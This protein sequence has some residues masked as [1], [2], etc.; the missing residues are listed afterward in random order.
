MPS[1]TFAI[2]DIHGCDRALAALVE[3]IRPTAD[4][5]LV[6]L[7][8]VVDRGPGT[9]QAIEQLLELQQTCRLVLILGNHDEMMIEGLRTGQ[10]IR[11]WLI[12]GGL[13]SVESYG[14]DPAHIPPEHLEFLESGLN[15]WQ[16][17]AHIFIHANLEPGVP[18]GQQTPEWL[19]WTHVSGRELPH[20]SGRRVICGHTSLKNGVP[21]VLPGW[22]C[23]DT[24]AFGGK[25]LTALDVEADLVYR[26]D[27]QGRRWEPVPLGEIATDL[28]ITPLD[29]VR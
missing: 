28:R 11:T 26:A 27:Q 17:D 9:R 10:T 15:Y 21:A 7:G 6:V 12:L 24:H 29:R 25:P 20:P 14:G 8:D 1:R 22:V 5:T 18:L 23:I 16:T 4:D 13:A 2:G 19:R 3:L